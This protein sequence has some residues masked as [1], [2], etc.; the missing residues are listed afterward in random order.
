ME[1]LLTNKEE[2]LK[3]YARQ[4]SQAEE[5]WRQETTGQA[6]PRLLAAMESDKVAASRAVTQNN[7]LKEQMIE[8]QEAFARLVSCFTYINGLY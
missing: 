8:L 7:K 6:D 1:A 2:A 4:L 5:K 3:D